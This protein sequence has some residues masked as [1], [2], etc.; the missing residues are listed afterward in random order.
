MLLVESQLGPSQD[1]ARHPD[2]DVH[3]VA[4][5][6]AWRRALRPSG[7]SWF[8]KCLWIP[9]HNSGESPLACAQPW[10]WP[11]PA[12][13][14]PATN[15]PEVWQTCHS[16]PADLC[17]P[18]VPLTP[19]FSP[20]LRWVGLCKCVV[21]SLVL[22]GPPCFRYLAETPLPRCL[23]PLSGGGHSPATWPYEYVGATIWL[24]FFLWLFLPANISK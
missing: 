8:R 5:A 4:R 15:A 23:L 10:Y 18:S 2:D 6:F 17:S 16:P 3:S 1:A 24:R 22:T 12:W 13:F 11:S 7:W 19:V 9:L 21:L 20:S 14:A